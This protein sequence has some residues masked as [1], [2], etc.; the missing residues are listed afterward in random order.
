MSRA[1]LHLW[2]AGSLPIL[3]LEA[4]GSDLATTS[5]VVAALA[6]SDETCLQFATFHCLCDSDG[7]A[8]AY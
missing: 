1:K 5:I 8:F 7:A 4:F 6:K 2:L 3:V